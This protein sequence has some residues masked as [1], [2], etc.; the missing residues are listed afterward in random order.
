MIATAAKLREL[1]AAASPGSEAE[2]TL[3]GHGGN[4]AR[5]VLTL[6]E[7][8]TGAA[9]AYHYQPGASHPEGKI[10]DCDY[11]QCVR[12]RKALAAVEELEP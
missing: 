1:L 4:F 6:S 2:R 5:L 12:Y 11:P 10:E 9:N 7:E 3:A 8:L